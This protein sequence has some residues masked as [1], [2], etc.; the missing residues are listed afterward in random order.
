M[1]RN[2]IIRKIGCPHLSLFAG[3]DYWYF[4][5]D[6]TKTGDYETHSVYT[7]YL[8]DLSLEEWIKEGKAFVAKYMDIIP[9]DVV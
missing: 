9:T 4:V 8:H 3:K 5:Y 6:N 1:T 2:Q 7:E